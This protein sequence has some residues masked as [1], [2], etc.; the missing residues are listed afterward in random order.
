MTQYHFL[1]ESG[2]PGLG[3]Q[4][5]SSEFFV[6]AMVQF[7]QRVA[8]V[9]LAEVRRRF[10]LPSDFEFKFYRAK[11]RQKVAI[12][13]AVRETPF[14][15]R[16][17]VIDKS[18]LTVP[19]THMTGQELI[20][21]FIVG[22]AMRASA[23]DLAGDILMV[24]GAMPAFLRALRVRLS[25]E[26]RRLGRVRP[27]GTIVSGKSHR[28]DELQLADMIAGAI[29]EHVTG[30]ESLYYRMFA[31]KVVDLWEVPGRGQ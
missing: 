28:H 3:G 15:I 16:A 29:R 11:S 10:H 13:E 6:L 27:F 14:R 26:S 24:D 1:D 21:E 7:P 9:K 25:R 18:R 23:L 20:V 12:F 4:P 31:D 22:L 19:F 17:V 2:D 5:G 30:E 8:L